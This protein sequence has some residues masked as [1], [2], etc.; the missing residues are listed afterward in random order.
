MLVTKHPTFKRFWYPV[1]PIENLHEEPKAFE[2]LGQKLVVWLAAD[3]QPA[4]AADRCCHRSAQLSKGKVNAGNIACSYH[5]WEFAPTGECVRVPQLEA[6]QPIPR[7]YQ[8]ST[9]RC[10]ERYGYAWVCLDEPLYPIPEIQEV[11]DTTFR[12]IHEFYEPWRV[13]G[14][15]VMENEFDLAHPTFVHTTTFGSEEHPTPDAMELVETEY[16]IKTYGVLGVTNPLLQQQNLKM[17]EAKTYRTL[18]MEW[19]VPFTCRLRIAYPNGLVHV[20]VNTAV[21]I[22]DTTSQIVQFCMRNDTEAETKAADAI[23]FDRAVTLEDKA[24]L[25]TTDPDVPLSTDGEQHMAT[26][27]PGLLMRRKLAAIL[28]QYEAIDRDENVL[29]RELS[30]L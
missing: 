28:R 10:E 18:E 23:A 26:D 7:T 21:P 17:A 4:A 12:L 13:A 19:F 22:D 14:L 6:G 20:V 30:V 8:I 1:V 3:G 11:S 27:R 29:E 2:L 16:G 24:I 15:R 5:G 9:Y 25:E